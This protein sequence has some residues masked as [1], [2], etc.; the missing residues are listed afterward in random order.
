[1]ALRGAKPVEVRSSEGL[2]VDRARTVSCLLR[3]DRYLL[4]GAKGYSC[5]TAFWYPASPCALTA[6]NRWKKSPTSA[7]EIGFV[8]SSSRNSMSALTSYRLVRAR[9]FTRQS[10]RLEN[11]AS[12]AP[13]IEAIPVAT[14]ANRGNQSILSLSEAP[15][16]TVANA[17]SEAGT[18]VNANAARRW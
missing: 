2:G 12:Q 16:A 10:F 18:T 11:S 7:S 6:F 13:R 17:A 8:W 4:A 3:R 14:I 5:P 1:M 9:L 15:I